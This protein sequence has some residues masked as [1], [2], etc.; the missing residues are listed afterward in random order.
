[1]AP[2]DLLENP[3][4]MNGMAAK[5]AEAAELLSMMAN[6]VRLLLL[7][8]LVE[9]EKS[10]NQLVVASDVSQSTVS[11]HLAKL[12]SL[13]LVATRRD[14]QTIYYRLAGP[15]VQKILATLHS[16]YCPKT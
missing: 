10:V 11:Q 6:P 2:Q 14:A 3:T 15:E 7:C 5:A 1:M 16:I 9:G 13:R 4:N 12:R 8:S